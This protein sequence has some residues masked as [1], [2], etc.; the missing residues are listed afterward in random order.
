MTSAM[1]SSTVSANAPSLFLNVEQ[2]LERYT[3]QTPRSRAH[4]Q[5]AVDR[6]AGGTTRTTVFFE[7]YPPVMLRGQGCW[8][9]DV[10]GNQRIDFLA[11]YTSLILGHAHPAVNRAVVEQVERG[12]AFAAPTANELRLAELIGA[13]VPSVE[14][15]RF[16]NSGTEA[17]MFAVRL[18]RGFTRRDK[19]LI[20]EGGYH[21]THDY[22]ASR[23]SVGIPEVVRATVV[24]A[25]YNNLDEVTRVVRET[26]DDL[27]A[28]LVEPYMGGAGIPAKPE[29]MHGLRELTRA[30]GS[31]LVMDEVISLRLSRGG[32]QEMYGV[33]P[34]LTTMGKIIGGGYPVAAFGGRAEIM[35]QLEPRAAG[36]AIPHGGTFNGN[37]VGT[38]AGI[39]TLELLTPDVYTRLNELGERA[40]SQL[41]GVFDKLG[42]AAQV[43]GMGS[44]FNLHFCPGE[45]TDYASS[46]AGA[47]EQSR[48]MMLALLNEGFFLAPRG[49]G[50]ITTPMSETEID[51]LASAIERILTSQS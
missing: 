51:A 14:R 49:M 45:I 10:D 41:T 6:L 46:R 44:L 1:T 17:T 50:C 18:A 37:P 15:L 2:V 9:E 29:F 5:R 26:G 4:F 27:A 32:V 47:N 11:N 8:V 12:S 21:G 43:T 28:V 31:L 34:D 19:V 30:N 42:V 24:T 33:V 40:R 39:A 7:P 48:A 36:P 35:A 23:T 13:R 22:A 16:A 3:Q 38:A 20:F 25:P